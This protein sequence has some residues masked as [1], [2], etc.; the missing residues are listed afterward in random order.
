MTGCKRKDK[1]IQIRIEQE[2]MDQLDIV[3]DKENMVRSKV[4]RK[5]ILDFVS[6]YK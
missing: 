1:I 6:T 5:L 2:L 4:I 3:C